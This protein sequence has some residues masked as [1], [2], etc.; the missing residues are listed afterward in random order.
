MHLT[1]EWPIGDSASPPFYFWPSL[2]GPSAGV[3]RRYGGHRPG[4]RGSG[5]GERR[6]PTCA[7][8][9]RAIR[10]QSTHQRSMRPDHARPTGVPRGRSQWAAAGS[11][12][13]R[14]LRRPAPAATSWRPARM[15]IASWER[16]RR[17]RALSE[18]EWCA[19]HQAHEAR[20]LLAASIELL[21]AK[22]TK[23]F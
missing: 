21:T 23:C 17:S 18:L 13:A 7:V 15:N 10:S 11:G 22:E 1:L 14:Q 9:R 4:A 2:A 19:I 16:L 3:I 6:H 20:L 5:R 8:C 12:T